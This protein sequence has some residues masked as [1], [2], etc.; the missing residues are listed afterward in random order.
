MRTVSFQIL[1]LFFLVA[2]EGCKVLYVSETEVEYKNISTSIGSE[3]TDVEAIIAPYR[4]DMDATMEEVIGILEVDLIKERPESNMGNWLADIFYEEANALISEDLDFAVMNQGGLRRNTLS[5][6]PI[7]RGEIFELIP[8]DNVVSVIEANGK[9][10]MVFLNHIAKGKGWPV[11]QQIK[12]EIKDGTAVNVSIDD[13]PL[14]VDRIYRFAVPD[15]VA[16]G[17]SGSDMLKTM[18]RTDY[19]EII[20]ELTIVHLK[21][22]YLDGVTYQPEIEGRIKN[23]DHE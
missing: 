2:S 12:M 1:L 13:Q 15:Y 14:D 11:S 5:K 3:D 4:A 9:E 10:V 17:G 7:S 8:F 23:L 20:R 22:T 18:K 19:D 6:G 21:K 16:G